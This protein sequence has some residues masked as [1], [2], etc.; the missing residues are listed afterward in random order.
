MGP[1]AAQEFARR[2]KQLQIQDNERR[3]WL[4]ATHARLEELIQKYSDSCSDL[5]RE[6][7]AGRET[8]KLILEWEGRFTSLRQHVDDASF[9][10]LLLD[11]DADEYVFKDEY[12]LT[13]EGGRK[14]ACE[15]HKL[16]KEYIGTLEPNLAHLPIVIKAFAN[17]NGMSKFL[18]DFGVTKPSKSLWNF[19]KD[20]SQAHASSDFVLV[21][22]G[23]DRA[24]KKIKGYFEQFVRNPTCR[25]IILGASHDN[26][27]VRMLEDFSSDDSVVERVTLLHSYN[28]GKEFRNLPF[29]STK[30][31]S[32]F[33]DA[34]PKTPGNDSTC[35]DQGT[36]ETEEI[37]AT[38]P[39]TWAAVTG[40]DQEPSDNST[41]S[42]TQSPTPI[43]VSVNKHGHR[44]DQALPR[45]TQSATDSWNYK[46]KVAKIRYCRAYHL[47]D[48]CPGGCGFSHGSLTDDEKGMWRVSLRR[49][50]CY[51]G[52]DCR[53]PKCYYGHNCFCKKTDCK[54]TKAEHAVHTKS[55]AL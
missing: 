13:P 15:L 7:I 47:K 3:D 25:H 21:G 16:A 34:S 46:I 30:M 18:S 20:F 49:E 50:P 38:I 26:G 1:E 35:S 37:P 10:L 55:S 42:S 33:R 11:A 53:R 17:G 32:V 36:V 22:S 23:K 39:S 14:A 28:I 8:Q 48:G 54:F 12:Y 19:A 24:D 4:E 41:R 43:A 45:P 6:R 27:Y 29:R 31:E 9:V 2:I 5:E 40:I 52:L 51:D 44:I